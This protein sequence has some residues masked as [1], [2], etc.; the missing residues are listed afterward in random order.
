[1]A[2]L[3]RASKAGSG[4]DIEVV[5]LSVVTR[6]RK[7]I[8]DVHA[9]FAPK[10]GGSC[11]LVDLV[12]PSCIK[13]GTLTLRES[14]T[15]RLCTTWLGV[16]APKIS[17]FSRDLLGGVADTNNLAR[18]R[19]TLWKIT[20]GAGEWASS[21]LILR[22]FGRDRASDEGVW[23][24]AASFAIDIPTLTGTSHLRE[25]RAP[26]ARLDLWCLLF[27]CIFA[28]LAEELLKESLN[29][30]QQGVQ[31]RLDAI[32]LAIT[33][34]HTAQNLKLGRPGFS[35][36]GTQQANTLMAYDI[37]AAADTVVSLL[38]SEFRSLAGD[39]WSLTERGD[40]TAADA[41]STSF[42]LLCV[43]MT[44]GLVN[45]LRIALQEIH[46]CIKSAAQ[47]DRQ[48]RVYGGNTKELDDA[49]RS[50]AD[51]GLT[52]G[53][54]AWMLRGRSGRPLQSALKPPP[55]FAQR[56]RGRIEEQ[57]LEAAF[58]IAD[59]DG[60]GVVD[61][62]EAAEALQAVSFG[63]SAVLIVDPSPYP[64]LTLSEFSL[65]ATRLLEEQQP[66]KH[67]AACLDG[68]LAESLTAWSEW[69]LRETAA[70]LDDGC[71]SF[72]DLCRCTGLT[73]DVW[74]QS[75][76]IWE[77]RT[78]E[79]D[80]DDGDGIQESIHFPVMISPAIL[81]YI[82]GVAAELS[83]ILSTVD[84]LEAPPADVNTASGTPSGQASKD[85]RSK[86]DGWAADGGTGQA[87]RYA[88]SLAA[89]RAVNDLKQV[90]MNLCDG[91]HAPA[92][93]AC[94]AAQLQLLLDALFLQK[95]T[96]ALEP[97]GSS[98]SMKSIVF[99]LCELVDPVNLQIYMP[100]LQAAASACCAACHTS[101]S[102]IFE[103]TVA[104]GGS[105]LSMSPNGMSGSSSTFVTLVPK[106][107]RFELLPLPL[108]DV[109]THHSNGSS[110]G[111]T[112][113]GHKHG[114][115][116]VGNAASVP[117]QASGME[118]GRQALVGLMGQ[119]GNVRSVFSASLFLGGGNRRT[120]V[121]EE[122]LLSTVF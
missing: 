113:P 9:I 24:E 10:S 119:V 18:I 115:S 78:I 114:G 34:N 76:G 92:A 57:Q 37:L 67:L 85:G 106:A 110:L 104:H 105:I 45:H 54:V 1:M 107:R 83:R 2:M 99:T 75:H 50:F 5:L 64:S 32:L 109:R 17:A 36:D 82:E 13:K 102:L 42:Y 39:A 52:I 74:R 86:S 61:A 7:T 117:T 91:S 33:G 81:C 28:D 73:D 26:P 15:R 58:V 62:E 70:L 6:I 95:W 80:R 111:R 97:Q 23:T 16:L 112:S 30:I 118:A 60:D 22:L 46:A 89:A 122:A 29:C 63:S 35:V 87:A 48:S 98:S 93:Q 8:V 47:P 19:G 120:D 77:D 96:T 65:L 68:L 100:H 31:R 43:E 69:A 4:A 59:T 116:D 40:K 103:R 121:D 3:R 55:C 49:M 21:A 101:L 108:D 27:S 90:M 72:A 25:S 79:L 41:L 84:L 38:T 88:R 66:R 56:I 51:A 14:D 20:H 53:R 44:V 71:Q 12:H 11:M 94:E